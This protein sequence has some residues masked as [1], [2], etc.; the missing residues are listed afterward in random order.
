LANTLAYFG[1]AS[2]TGNESFINFVL[3]ERRDQSYKTFYGRKLRLL[4][5]S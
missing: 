1:A 2:M 3:D 5:I 4:V